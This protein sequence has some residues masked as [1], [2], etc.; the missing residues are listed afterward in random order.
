[1]KMKTIKIKKC[2]QQNFSRK[3]RRATTDF[4]LRDS[5]SYIPFKCKFAMFMH[6]V[7]V[8]HKC[9]KSK[10]NSYVTTKLVYNSLKVLNFSSRH[11]WINSQKWDF[12]N[13]RY[14]L[15][16]AW[17][18]V[19]AHYSPSYIAQITDF[20]DFLHEYCEEIPETF[21]EF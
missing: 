5:K 17:R 2:L 14:I 7:L 3:V 1:M 18:I 10:N 13:Y 6:F 19:I 4:L 9:C 21:T 11:I 16:V 12:F 20:L 15:Y 8:L